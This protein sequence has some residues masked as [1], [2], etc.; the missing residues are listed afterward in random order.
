MGWGFDYGLICMNVFERCLYSYNNI[1][2]HDRD[3]DHV[4]IC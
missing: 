4:R 1:R 3:S 2:N